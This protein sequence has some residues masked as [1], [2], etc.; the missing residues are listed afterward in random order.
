MKIYKECTKEPFLTID[1]KLS[2]S[3]PI[4]FRNK[5]LDSYKNDSN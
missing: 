4:K 1:T 3:D 2:E 5:L